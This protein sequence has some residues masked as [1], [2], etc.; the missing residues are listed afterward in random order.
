MP[1]VA[2]SL[3]E[4]FRRMVAR[5]GGELTLLPSESDLIRVRYRPGA[6]DPDCADGSCSLP[7]QELEQLMTETASRR[8]AGLRVQVEVQ[9]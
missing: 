9:R 2:D 7:E 1:S 3:V 4:Q 8:R 5:D 6:A